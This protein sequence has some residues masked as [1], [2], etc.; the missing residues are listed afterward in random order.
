M[1]WTADDFFALEREFPDRLR[2]RR[3]LTQNHQLIFPIP[4]LK[5]PISVLSHIE[6]LDA[7]DFKDRNSMENRHQLTCQF[8]VFMIKDWTRR[9]LSPVLSE[10]KDFYFLAIQV[11][12]L[13]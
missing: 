10:P 7:P 5:N 4:R 6:R 11:K 9:P 1:V 3:T 12:G 2:L 13:I 8:N